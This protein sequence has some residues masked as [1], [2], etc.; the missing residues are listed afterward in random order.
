[1]ELLRRSLARELITAA[2]CLCPLSA[3]A[4][5]ETGISIEAVDA[6]SCGALSNNIANVDN[7]R[8]RMLSI[9]GYS[10][11][12]RYTNGLVWP[13]DFTDVDVVDV[14]SPP[15]THEPHRGRRPTGK[16]S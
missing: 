10:A 12:V 3:W 9:G 7:F 14:C 8:S 6:Y 2:L 5:A 16:R 11:G 15:A 13:T 1:M 4:A